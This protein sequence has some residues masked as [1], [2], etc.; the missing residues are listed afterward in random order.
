MK[1]REVLLDTLIGTRLFEM[2][3]ERKLVIDRLMSLQDQINSHAIKII[4]WP[5]AQEVPHWKHELTAWGDNLA[6]MWLKGR[7]SRPMGFDLAWKILYIG[8]FEGLEARAI[9]S[10]LYRLRRDYPYPIA[11]QPDQILIELTAFLRALCQVIGQGEIELVDS[12]I[13]P[14]GQSAPPVPTMEVAAK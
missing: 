14:L 5:D 1:I 6:S 9:Q 4:V 10:R 12:V 3:F 13:E 7:P 8:P 11:K 2:A